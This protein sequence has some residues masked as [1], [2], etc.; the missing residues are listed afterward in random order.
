[1]QLSPLSFLELWVICKGFT[2]KMFVHLLDC[3]NHTVRDQQVNKGPR[4][5][6]SSC[7]GGQLLFLPPREGTVYCLAAPSPW[8]LRICETSWGWWKILNSWFFTVLYL[9]WF[10][11]SFQSQL[12]IWIL[13][14]QLLKCMTFWILLFTDDIYL[15]KLNEQKIMNDKML[16]NDTVGF[17]FCEEQSY[18]AI[19][20]IKQTLSNVTPHPPTSTFVRLT[21]T[22]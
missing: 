16:L 6:M 3:Y 2:G 7:L 4:E 21:C 8:V 9:H 11:F 19:E 1:M 14:W 18:G 10:A 22:G 20:H 15:T 13:D 12:L 17:N 5:A